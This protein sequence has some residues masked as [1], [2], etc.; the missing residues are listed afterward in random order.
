MSWTTGEMPTSCFRGQNSCRVPC[1]TFHQY[2]QIRDNRH[3]GGRCPQEVGGQDS[4][5]TNGESSRRGNTTPV[6]HV[7][8]GR[9]G[10]HRPCA[11]GPHGGGSSFHDGLDLCKQHA[12]LDY[13]KTRMVEGEVLF[14]IGMRLTTGQHH[15]SQQVAKTTQH[16]LHG[17]NSPST[18]GAVLPKRGSGKLR[19]AVH[20]NKPLQRWSQA[21]T[22]GWSRP[23]GLNKC[24]FTHHEFLAFSA[25]PV[26][27]VFS[28]KRHLP[29]FPS[30]LNFQNVKNHEKGNA[31]RGARDIGGERRK[32][33]FVPTLGLSGSF[34]S[35][36]K[37]GFRFR[38]Q[39][40]FGVVQGFLGLWLFGVQGSGCLTCWSIKGAGGRRAQKKLKCHKGQNRTCS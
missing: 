17:R 3:R 25:L 27:S 8:E 20:A 38:V 33:H 37:S 11:P 5:P 18:P 15:N 12:A 26:F 22:L 13:V 9:N 23:V 7:H 1:S 10:M 6:C 29:C 14:Y 32:R 16:I 24:D 28:L 19:D 39:G 31:K 35:T 34:C 21:H 36:P 4:C 40:L 30:P 2:P